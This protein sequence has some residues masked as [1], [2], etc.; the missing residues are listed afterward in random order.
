MS[1]NQPGPY[2]GQ[3]PQQPGPYGQQPG[4]PG[5]YGQQPQA[6]QPGYGYPQQAP[7]GVPPQQGGYSQP[8]QP[9]P[10]GQQQQGPYGQ[11]PPPPPA[12][13]GSGKKTGLIIGA[14]V[15]LVAI[16]GGVWWF[17]AGKDD[18]SSAGN[19]AV[20]DD[21]K[22]KLVTPETVLSEYKKAVSA[23]EGF[24]DSD[25]KRAEK[26]GVK[27]GEPVDAE[28]QSGDKSN[29]L[30]QKMIK[31]MGVYGDIDDPSK[32]VDGM[33]DK[34]A[35][36]SEKEGAATSTGKLVGSPKS[37]DAD[38]AVIKCQETKVKGGGS[39]PKEISMPVC[40]WGDHS[41]L[42][43]VIPVDMASAMSGKGASLDDAADTATK[44]RKEVRV[45][46]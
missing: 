10:Y 42:G 2:G 23:G 9:G 5:P 24:T 29:P 40:I 15:A 8:Q 34:M 20:A 16:G 45:K 6:P 25:M 7:Q 1:Y 41:T 22:H 39:G 26:D 27:N 30:A 36:Q 33:F 38:G 21:G 14:I 35:T 13:G 4:Q 31:F 12:G 3:Q 32:V 17:T 43:V 18:S 44:L 11:V 46:A 28:Y 19:S 37:F